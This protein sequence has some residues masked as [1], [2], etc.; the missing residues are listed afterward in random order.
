[1]V[2]VL[3]VRHPAIVAIVAAGRARQA[4]TP[5]STVRSSAVTVRVRSAGH[6]I[7]G[8]GQEAQDG[9][10]PGVAGTAQLVGGQRASGAGDLGGV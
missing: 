2:G 10:I 4:S 5:R 3:V 7:A 6:L 8:A 9:A 1:V